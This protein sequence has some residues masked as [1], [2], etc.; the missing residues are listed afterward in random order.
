VAR[1]AV[2]G[3]DADVRA[4]PRVTA[5][6]GEPG[7]AAATLPPQGSRKITVQWSPEREPKM[8]QVFAHVVVTTTDE[9]AGEVAMGVV[10]RVPRP[11]PWIS[12]HLLSWLVF[13]PVAAAAVLWALRKLARDDDRAV[14]V[15]ALSATLAQAILAGVAYGRFNPDVTRLDG[16]D[17]LQLVEHVVW[18]R[19]IS[20]EYFVG[21]DGLNVTLVLLV[22]L[23]AVCAVLG[24]WAGERPRAFFAMLLFLDAGLVG[25][26]VAQDLLLLF[27]FF[28]LVILTTAFLVGFWGDGE[29]GRAAMK[30]ALSAFAGSACLLVAILALRANADRTFL[31]DGTATSAPFSIHELARVAFHAKKLSLLGLP[32]AKVAWVALFVGFVVLLPAFPLHLWLADAV[33]AIPAPAAALVVGGTLELGWYGIVRVCYPILP[34]ATRWASGFVVALGVVT[35]V[36]ASLCAMGQRDLKRLLAYAAMAHGGVCLAG[37]GALTPQGIAGSIFHGGARGIALAVLFLLAGAL[38]KRAR[39]RDVTRF[40]GLAREVPAFSLLFCVA[41]LGSM[42]VPGLAGFWGDLLVLFG[43]FPSQRAVTILAAVGLVLAASFHLWLLQRAIFGRFS[44]AW[45]RSAVLE[46][47]GGKFPDLTP[48]ELASVVPLVFLLVLLG[49]WPTPILGAIAGGVRDATGFVNPPGPDQIARGAPRERDRALAQ[50]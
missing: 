48:R 35:L 12:D 25:A 41:A 7:A 33:E 2:R 26:L 18:V 20:A 5:R 27:C 39:T 22:P 36:Y 1:G 10:A 14:R 9:R 47:F 32:L 28:Q 44:D 43:A 46:P 34:E 3:D 4:P 13:L 16:N 40:G 50:R 8:R 15:T 19:A 31:V 29:R 49:V 11:L 45:R 37:V 38:E 23:V 17:G 21:L 6:L 42:G 24:A 30:L